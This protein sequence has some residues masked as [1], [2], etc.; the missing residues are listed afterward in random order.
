[1]H[2]VDAILLFLERKLSK[3]VCGLILGCISLA[4]AN[5]YVTPPGRV[6]NHGQGY[7]DLTM[8]PFNF[9]SGSALQ[10]RILTPLIGHYLLPTISADSFIWLVNGI[11]VLFLAMIYVAARREDLSPFTSLLGASIMGFSAPVLFFVHFAGYTDIT[12]YL[13]TFLAILTVRYRVLWMIFLGLSLLNHERNFFNY[14]W[15][16]AFYYLRNHHSILK[17]LRAAV[18][19]GIS[20]LPWL[21]YV[22]LTASYKPPEYS[23]SYYLTLNPWNMLTLTAANFYSGFFQAFKLFW[24]IPAYAIAQLARRREYGEICLYVMIVVSACAQ[25]CLAHDTSRLISSAFPVVWFGFIT[26]AKHGEVTLTI[27]ALAHL[28]ILNLFVPQY[29]V[30]QNVEIRF[31]SVP[32]SW[33]LQ[34]YFA[35]NTWRS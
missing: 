17:A 19:M 24:A 26:L 11:G 29:Y 25:L 14:P 5:I 22:S 31:Y 15:F 7:L 30:G 13:L 27:K 12:S 3:L 1:M 8:T 23:V 20:A 9:Q 35:N 28:F 18:L 4:L 32:W 10:N 34:R 2:Y 6:V 21:W 33:F 16:L